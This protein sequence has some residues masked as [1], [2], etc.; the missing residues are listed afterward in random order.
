MRK[1]RLQPVLAWTLIGAALLWLVCDWLFVD[2]GLRYFSED[3]SR[4]V[5]L[6]AIVAA[7]TPVLLGYELLSA[8]RRRRMELLVVGLSA[9]AATGFAVHFFFR[10][11]RLAGFLRESGCLWWGL[12]AMLF[13]SLIAACLWWA[14][15]RIRSRKPL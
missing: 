11:T 15:S 12:L 1:P 13:P 5:V 2:E 14:F 4:V 9:V 10:M 7:G 8:E 3:R 6:L